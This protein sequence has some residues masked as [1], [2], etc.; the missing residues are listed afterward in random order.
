MLNIRLLLIMFLFT[1]LFALSNKSYSNID[2]YQIIGFWK[3][4]S[5]DFYLN[6]QHS[7]SPSE[8]IH[9]HFKHNNEL[10]IFRKGILIDEYDWE[11]RF[12][13]SEGKVLTLLDKNTKK[14]YKNLYLSIVYKNNLPLEIEMYRRR[15]EMKSKIVLEKIYEKDID[16]I[17]RNNDYYSLVYVQKKGAALNKK[18][19]TNN[20]LLHKA[21]RYCNDEICL[22]LIN[23]GQ[24]NLNQKNN[25][26][27]TALTLSLYKRKFAVFR[28]L[29]QKNVELDVNQ[30]N[31]DNLLHMAVRTGDLKPVVDVVKKN[32]NFLSEK[33]NL[34]ESPLDL[35]K[36]KNYDKITQ[37]LNSIYTPKI[38]KVNVDKSNNKYK[39]KNFQI[40]S[41][42]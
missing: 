22:F 4:I 24:I 9:F 21:L 13:N 18:D 28:T 40:Q 16:I 31:G 35:S 2:A 20:T 8:I 29:I 1:F 27:E 39:L 30:E 23:N 11:I 42:L 32:K 15:N 6:N 7:Y 41:D 37:Y 14:V 19:E 26:G 17:I 36:K 25:K 34:G 3:N 12:L 38:N 5:N 33:N 10:Q